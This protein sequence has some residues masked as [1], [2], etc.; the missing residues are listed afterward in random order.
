MIGKGVIAG[1]VFACLFGLALARPAVAG[2]RPF[3]FTVDGASDL[4]ATDAPCTAASQQLPTNVHVDAD[5]MPRI[6][7]MLQRSP[8]FREQCQ[9]LAANLWVHVAVRLD[10]T[11][12]DRHA[13]RAATVIQR[14]QAKLII[15]V[16]SLQ[17]LADPAMWVSHEFE[18][19]IEQIEAVDVASLADQRILAWPSGSGMY[20]TLR[21][22]RAGEAVLGEVRGHERDSKFVD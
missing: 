8:T 14:P 7:Q 18:H 16:V 3:G 20:E 1:G 11:F 17:G 13:I 9:R 4:V 10:P 15:A 19:L 22:I 21:A 6:R 2:E 5:V 12:H